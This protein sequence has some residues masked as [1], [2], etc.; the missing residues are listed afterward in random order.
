MGR[1]SKLVFVSLLLLAVGGSAFATE[2]GNI[3]FG[4]LYIHPRLGV[5]A[6]YD[7]NIFLLGPSKEEDILFKITPGIDFEYM[8]E[9]KSAS[10]S[11]L[12]EIGRYADNTSHDYEN[13]RVDAGVDLQFPSGL[14]FSV[15]DVF[16]RTND[17]LTY[18]WIPLVERRENTTDVKVGYE[19]TDR[20]SFR[21]GYD[22]QIIDYKAPEYGV[23]DRD[24]DIASATAFYRI[25][26][27]VSLLGQFEYT[28]INYDRHAV[29][30]DGDGVGGWLGVTGEITPKMTVLVKGGWQQRDYE[31]SQQD[32][33][34]AVF[35][36]DI[37]HR[38]T[39]TLILTVG[40]SREAV[41]S[42]YEANNYYASTRAKAGLEKELGPRMA[43]S[44]SGFYVNNDYPESDPGR[45]DN[46]WGAKVAVRYDLQQWLSTTLSYTYQNRDSN[47]AAYDY[48]D[49][50]VSLGVSGI[51]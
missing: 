4:Q 6:T 8:R 33:D 12:A 40:G 17:R 13:H 29:R 10:L 2:V 43:A 20:L 38:C 28:Q 18:E 36:V 27:A 21:V 19:F 32:W 37:V 26:N 41:E 49:N 16:R 30:T 22:H 47:L 51:F 7:D 5:E 48:E 14:M 44:V 3:H 31:G 39:E 45:E 1:P 15:G 46:V 24:V 42:T 34:G 23:F 11:Y 35:S 9:G 50:Q 25:L